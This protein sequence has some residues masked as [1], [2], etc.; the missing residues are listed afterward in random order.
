MRKAL[1]FALPAAVVLL[2]LVLRLYRIDWQSVWYDEAFSVTVAGTPLGPM[3]E[4][5]IQD[6]VHPPLHYYL[7]HATFQA[8]GYGAA[9]ARLLSALFG[10][11]A[12]IM[13]YLLGEYLFDRRTGL[14]AALLLAVSQLGVM[15][16]QEA[17]PYAQAL[18]L[19]ITTTYL[20]IRA[21]S[22][23]RAVVWWGFVASAILMMYTFYFEVFV[24][25]CLLWFAVA[26]R[27]QYPVPRRWWLTGAGVAGVLYLPW[28]TSGVVGRALQSRAMAPAVQDPST[29]VHWHSFLG[30]INW[31]NNGKVSGMHAPSPWWAFLAGAV[32]F[33]LPAV[34]ALKPLIKT[35]KSGPAEPS[36]PETLWLLAV[37][38]MVPILMVQGLGV[39]HVKYSVRY[40]V[41]CTPP[42]YLLVAR[43]ITGLKARLLGVLLA[44]ALSAYSLY[45]LRANYFVPYKEDFRGSLAYLVSAYREGDCCI[46]FPASR[47]GRAPWYWYVY[48]RERPELR[49]TDL[50]A[51]AS[52]RVSCSRV[53]LLRDNTWWRK[54]DRT[55]YEK[56]KETLET[57]YSRFERRPST[58]FDISLYVPRA[59]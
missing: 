51:L 58:G 9:Q 39:L 44:L 8:F 7:V 15:Y 25:A 10:T 16:S 6:C 43:G 48:H 52:G 23:R 35:A 28:M 37:L 5:L 3:T 1:G 30:A 54:W 53:W 29:L 57:T 50:E 20:F 42:Y 33:S 41:F 40:V 38:W 11:L 34:L 12:I 18:F 14:L 22:E 4:R 26:F 36:H 21:L 46:F 13:I 49:V 31:F 32:L 45:G 56:A 19:A 17:R 55:A 59:R 24:L 47:D 27:K 2:G